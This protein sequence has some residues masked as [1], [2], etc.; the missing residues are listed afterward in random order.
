MKLADLKKYEPIYVIG[1]SNIDIDSAVSSK[2]LCDIL[3]DFGIKAHYAIL[4]EKYEF[5]KYNQGMVKACMDFKPIIVKKEDINKYNWFLVDHNDRHQSV[6]LEVN[7]VGAIDHHPNANNVENVELTNV[8]ST[9]L[10]IF[11]EYKDKYEFTEEQK[12]QIYMA[13]LNDSTFGKSSRYKQSD[14]EIAK[15]LGFNYNY[16]ELFKKFFITTDITK[17]VHT[18][19]KNGHKKY[20]F[21]NVYFE[22]NY[23]EQFGIEKLED[24]KNIIKD[25]ESFLGVWVDYENDKTYA[26]FKYDNQFIEFKYDFIA[27]RATTILED[28][29]NYLKENK[30]LKTNEINLRRKI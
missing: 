30:Y 15:Q 1:H 29:I 23:I 19:M 2:I 16:N 8:C 22:S 6:G 28:V 27:S 5:D 14:E 21:D 13:F 4:D 9:A 7:V 20:Q 18:K 11:N 10:H 24:Y 12:Y 3:N 26:Y 17:G 25:M